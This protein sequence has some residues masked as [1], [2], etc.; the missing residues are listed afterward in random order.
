MAHRQNCPPYLFAFAILLTI[1]TT[2]SAAAGFALVEQSVSGLGNAYAG[3]A[4]SAEDASTVFFNPAGLMYLNG[5]QLVVGGHIIKP[6]AEFSGSATNALGAPVSGGDGGD[7][8]NTSLVPNL[9]YSR[10][11]P[12]NF[13][14]GLGI[15]APFGLKTE[16]DANWVGRLSRHR[17]G[18]QDHQHQSGDRIQ[19]R[20]QSFSGRWR[21]RSIHRGNTQSGHQPNVQLC[22]RGSLAKSG[23]GRCNCRSGLWWTACGHN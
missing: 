8:G 1:S 20:A 13:V 17:V 5:N 10:K 18:T 16:Y 2:Q 9:Y 21:E 14:F 4:A 7:A 12:N 19:G 11:L 3:A 22:G 15:N 23:Y 6:S